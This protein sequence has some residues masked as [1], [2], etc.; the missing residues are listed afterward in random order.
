MSFIKFLFSK[1]ILKQLTIALVVVFVLVFILTIWLASTTNHD[2]FREVPNLIGKKA[3]IAKRLLEK[4]DL[5]LGDIE[6]KDYNP[7][8]PKGVIVE[9]SPKFGAK[10]KEGRKVYISV[11]KTEYRKVEVPSLKNQTKR[12]AVTSLEDAG[13]KIGDITYIPH[14]AK[15]AVMNLKYKGKVITVSEKLPSTSIIDLV[16]GNG[17]LDYGEQPQT[18]EGKN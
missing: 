13:F 4:Q 3:E 8:F 2:G 17:E 6:Y 10:V 9:H 5:K 12:Q 16:L 15:D 18:E 14:F 1:T 7:K 11:N